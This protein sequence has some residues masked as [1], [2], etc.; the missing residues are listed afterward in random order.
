MHKAYLEDSDK[1]FIREMKTLRKPAIIVV[2]D[3]QLDDLV[4]FCTNEEEL[5]I[6]TINPTL[7]LGDF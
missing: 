1:C 2:L 4:K 5:G 3:R 7:S 6:L